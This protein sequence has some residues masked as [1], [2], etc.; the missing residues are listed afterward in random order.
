MH[1]EAEAGLRTG[2]LCVAR[3]PCACVRAGESPSEGVTQPVPSRG[4]GLCCPV[5]TGVLQARAQTHSE[6]LTALHAPTTRGGGALG[7]G[8][9]RPGRGRGSGCVLLRT[10]SFVRSPQR[11][12]RGA[13]SRAAGPRSPGSVGEPLTGFLPA[14]GRAPQVPVLHAVH[15]PALSALSPGLPVRQMRKTCSVGGTPRGRSPSAFHLRGV[16][17]GHGAG[18]RDSLP[19]LLRLGGSTRGHGHPAI[20][21]AVHYDTDTRELPAG[22]PA[23]SSF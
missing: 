7:G 15:L 17:G 5:A 10:E 16:S 11:G 3:G 12:A 2:P 8:P 19:Q 22:S 20:V 6:G 9:C 13:V 4:G 21:V 14:T 1:T 23:L 18:P